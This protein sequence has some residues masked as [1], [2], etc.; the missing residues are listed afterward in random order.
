MLACPVVHTFIDRHYYFGTT[1]WDT[2]NGISLWHCFLVL[3][4]CWYC[5]Q[6]LPFGTA[7]WYCPLALP[8]S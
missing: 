8:G 2:S 7:L 3:P 6:A 1:V 4:P 5:P